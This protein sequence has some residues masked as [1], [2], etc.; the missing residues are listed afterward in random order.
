M[1]TVLLLMLASVLAWVQSLPSALDFL[2]A[3]P[4]AIAA[5][6]LASEAAERRRHDPWTARRMP[7][8]PVMREAL[9]RRPVPPRR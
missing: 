4:F 6:G 7:G 5:L 8:R 9:A 2:F 3:L 1:K